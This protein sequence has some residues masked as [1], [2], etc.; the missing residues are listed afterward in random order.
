[1]ALF[2]MELGSPNVLM[3]NHARESI[4]IFGH[5][6]YIKLILWTNNV[7]MNEVE[8]CCRE[9]AQHRVIRKLNGIP[10]HVRDLVI[11]RELYRFA[12]NKS[13]ADSWPFLL[14]TK[15]QLHAEAHTE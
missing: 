11:R 15:Q 7:A 14:I 8:R 1:M 12:R 6:S 5:A 13:Q 2:G 4:A 3:N 10:A 9:I